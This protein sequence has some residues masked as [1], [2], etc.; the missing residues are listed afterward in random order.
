[1]G[2]FVLLP[3]LR[4][5]KKK[6]LTCFSFSSLFFIGELGLSHHFHF[7]KSLF[8]LLSLTTTPLSLSKQKRKNRL[9]QKRGFFFLC[10]RDE[11]TILHAEGF[12]ARIG[13]L[14]TILT[15]VN[16]F[17]KAWRLLLTNINSC[18]FTLRLQIS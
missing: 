15:S 6:V 17:F 14:V 18:F 16:Y 13:E 4:A 11:I 1:M 8:S 3:E 12:S 7:L 9:C 5:C 2:V 10:W